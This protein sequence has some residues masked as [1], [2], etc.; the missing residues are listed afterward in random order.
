MNEIIKEQLNRLINYNFY[1]DDKQVAIIPDDFNSL[2]I[3]KQGNT[4]T[5]SIKVIFENYF[6]DKKFKDFTFHD[7]FNK[8]IIPYAKVLYGEILKE[9]EKM[10]YFKGHSDS[11]SEIWEGWIPR[12]SC[13]IVHL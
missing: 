8:G 11:S 1:I 6:I 9:S 10:I 7:K 4:S 3:K 2:I 13:T 12:K 5:D